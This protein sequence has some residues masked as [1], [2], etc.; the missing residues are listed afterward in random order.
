MVYTSLLYTNALLNAFSGKINYPSDTIKVALLTSSYT[1]NQ[2][3]HDFFDDVTT[4]QVTA[5]GYT[6][7][8]ATL[9]SK[10][11]TVAS[12]KTIMLDS[13]D[14]TW[15]ITGSVTFRYAVVYD[16]TPATDATRPLISYMDFGEDQTMNDGTLKIT[17]HANG[18]VSL[19]VS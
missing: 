1:P 8:G 17:I 12:S 4:Y 7:G 16:A 15:T 9:G 3:T 18:I 19:T 2:D 10:T 11:L 6:A 13:G 5:T 14:V